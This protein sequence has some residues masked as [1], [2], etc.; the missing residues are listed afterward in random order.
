MKKNKLTLREGNSLIMALGM[1]TLIILIVISSANYVISSLKSTTRIE[2]NATAYF[3]AEKEMETALYE[4]A[5]DDYYGTEDKSLPNYDELSTSGYV[6]NGL[7]SG[8][9]VPEDGY[10]TFGG[11]VC[12]GGVYARND[13]HC[14]WNVLGDVDKIYLYRDGAK[15]TG[16][17]T[18]YIRTESGGSLYGASGIYPDSN[19]PTVNPVVVDWSIIDNAT[20]ESFRPDSCTGEKAYDKQISKLPTAIG[21]TGTPPIC[22]NSTP[23]DQKKINGCFNYYSTNNQIKAGDFGNGGVVINSNT[24][25]YNKENDT[26]GNTILCNSGMQTTIRGYINSVSEPILNLQL[27]TG[28]LLN[29]SG[30]PEKLLYRI[31]YN[32]SPVT[33]SYTTVSATATVGFFPMAHTVEMMTKI[34]NEKQKGLFSYAI[35]EK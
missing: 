18:I 4:V 3:L 34:P 26:S 22:S 19:D 11:S 35:F 2:S 7:A 14:D 33:E 21:V 15:F 8:G 5:S 1:S 32:G 12:D 23:I 20:G 10:G 28:G 16:T 29:S 31:E 24:K 13:N 9:A 30:K 27:V 25:G 17:F 6:I